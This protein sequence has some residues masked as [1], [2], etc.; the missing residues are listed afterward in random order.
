M[1]V[2]TRNAPLDVQPGDFGREKVKE[3]KSVCNCS[4]VCLGEAGKNRLLRWYF[5]TGVLLLLSSVLPVASIVMG[6]VGMLALRDAL[7]DMTVFLLA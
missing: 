5:L 4:R 6:N 2:D 1:I 3:L 7:M